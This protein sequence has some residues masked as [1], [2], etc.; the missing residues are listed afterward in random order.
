MKKIIFFAITMIMAVGLKAQPVQIETEGGQVFADLYQ[1]K[2]TDVSES[3]VSFKIYN[4][5][6][7][8]FLGGKW[9]KVNKIKGL[10]YNSQTM[11]IVGTKKTEIKK[12]GQS[13]IL[14]NIK[15]Q[16]K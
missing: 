5:L 14:T 10:L 6:N 8:N 15:H 4:N 12:D 1:I 16:K 9:V 11:K 13:F 2:F 7:T 3:H